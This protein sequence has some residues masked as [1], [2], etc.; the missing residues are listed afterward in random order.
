[1]TRRLMRTTGVTLA[2]LTLTLLSV[3]GDW[4]T[5]GDG[6]QELPPGPV[7]GRDELVRHPRLD[8]RL[9]ELANAATRGPVPDRQAAAATEVGVV[10]Q[11]TSGA[12]PAIEVL[13]DSLGA[14]HTSR[15]GDLIIATVPAA[16]LTALASNPAIAGIASQPAPIA[17]AID[18]Q[19][20]S[21]IDADQ[22]HAAGVTGA[23]VRVA[24][25]D[26][27]FQGYST[28]LGSELPS[29]V[30]TASFGCG[31]SVENLEDHGTAVAEI[32]HE[33][34]PTAELYLLCI[35]GSD[36]LSRLD[37]AVSYAVANGVD[38]IN[39]SVGWFNSGRGDGTG[40]LAPI[41]T[42][43]RN[44]GI[45]WVNSAGNHAQQH[46]MGNFSDP[47]TNNW[48]NFSG[49]DET[50]QFD[51]PTGGSVSARLRWDDWTIST[52]DFDLYLFR[53]P[54]FDNPVA[55]SENE[56]SPIGYFPVE[57]FS[58]TNNTS[59]GTFHLAIRRFDAATTPSM[60]L[61][62]SFNHSQPAIQH[63]VPARSITDPATSPIVMG[64]GA[65]CWS[66]DTIRSYSSRGPTI[67]GRIKPDLAGPDGVS[68]ATYGITQ[69]C[70]G[71][72]QGTSASSPHIAGAAALLRQAYPTA[73]TEDLHQIIITLTRD[74]G[75]AGDDNDYG[76]GILSLGDPPN[77]TV[78]LFD[79]SQ[80]QWHL[81][82]STG[83]VTSFYF[84]NPGD[85]PIMGD[86]NC[87]GLD[88]PGLY[89][90]SDGFVY[91]RNSNTQGVADITFFFG[92]PG[93]VPIAGD[94][95]NNGCDTV[96]IYRP[97]NQTFYIINALGQDGGGLG[98][99]TTSYVFGNPG[100]KP[101]TGDFNGNGQTTVGLHRETTG[102]VYYRNTHTQGNADNQFFF[103]DPGDRFVTGDWNVNGI[104]S[105]GIFRP[106]NTT[107]YFRFTNTQG[108]ADAQFVW[109]SSGWL[110]VSG[111]FGL[112]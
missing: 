47:D 4:A 101:F 25:I 88:T 89:R 8:Q 65:V 74:A 15:S 1:M 56:Q 108:N 91:L 5:A 112:G 11:A 45:L 14:G 22:W 36:A 38:V 27:G 51:L 106:S 70:N 75:V 109:G 84:G 63:N 87:D 2:A 102:L 85:Y 110:P 107:F 79:P 57:D 44:G 49:T 52:N 66:N 71:G 46:W 81:R 13:L 62:L 54:D 86:W 12:G 96:S 48:H 68:N 111:N 37:E 83:A 72:F 7:V 76:A 23:G 90:Q 104:D 61:F 78:G 53:A 30:H 58:Y 97:S 39:H 24:V 64:V 80:G 6:A 98:A 94:F 34:A 95:N 33:V 32:V 82:N 92:N 21:T 26:L 40:F 67:D 19:G 16:A 69:N 17:D 18:G 9:S 59:Q 93:D 35:G 50:I 100:D 105:P 20:V 43:A 28:L 31:A 77:Q 60:D 29:S 55:G 73:T 10:I 41:V 99:A 103:G 42:D 3:A